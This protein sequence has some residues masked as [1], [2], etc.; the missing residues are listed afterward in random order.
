MVAELDYV[1]RKLVR[2]ADGRVNPGHDVGGESRFQ[3]RLVL[4]FLYVHSAPNSVPNARSASMPI[5]EPLLSA[6]GND[7]FSRL[8]EG[9]AISLD[10]TCHARFDRDLYCVKRAAHNGTPARKRYSTGT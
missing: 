4:R 5:S 10:A 1:V 7:R 2:V 3:R 8:D 9:P 6:T